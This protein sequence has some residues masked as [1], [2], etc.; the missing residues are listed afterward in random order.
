MSVD[1]TKASAAAQRTRPRIAITLGDPNGIGPEVVLKALADRRLLK[2]MEPVIVGS[3]HVLQTH[4]QELGFQDTRFRVVQQIQEATPREGITVLDTAQGEK[5]I[6]AFGETNEAGGRLSMAAVE[7]A[8]AL[9]MKGHVDGM[10]TAPISKEAISLAGYQYAG[11]TEFL[12]ERTGSKSYTML[13]VAENLRIGLVTTH[14]PIWDVPKGVTRERIC[15]NVNIIHQ[16]LQNDFGI[17]RPRIAVLGLNPHAGDGGVM[18]TEETQTIIPAIEQC[19]EAGTL[20]FGPFAADGFFGM[21][22]YLHY[23]A[24]LAMYHDQGLIPF[25]TLAFKSGVNF[26]AGL[27]I[28]RTSPDHGTA[29]DIAGTGRAVPDS[30]RSAIY[31]ALDVARRRAQVAKRQAV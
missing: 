20:V 16:S 26:T 3:A 10:V 27:P 28:V 2:Y 8:I 15:E 9:C 11:H 7:Q 18:G 23:D 31:V 25:K 29:F 6:V 22:S 24:V 12:A 21:S 13:M 5:P 4:A 30:M 19:C 17:A 1:Q 14:L